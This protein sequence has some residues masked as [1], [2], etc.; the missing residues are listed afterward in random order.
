MSIKIVKSL[1]DFDAAFF[2]DHSIKSS[3]LY[4]LT[5]RSPKSF[6]MVMDTTVKPFMG[7]GHIADYPEQVL[8]ACIVQGWC[9]QYKW[10]FVWWILIL[11]PQV[12]RCD[13][14][15]KD[16]DHGDA[17]RWAHRHTEALFEAVGKNSLWD[18]YGIIS[19]IMVCFFIF[20]KSG[21]KIVSTAFYIWISACGY[22]WTLVARPPSSSY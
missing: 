7:W 9:P 2:M 19:D 22:P 17:G 5:W 10:L 6:A 18:D 14:H 20:P 15:W 12:S 21:I 1:A 8:L 16:L 3:S 4:Y 11:M 13:A